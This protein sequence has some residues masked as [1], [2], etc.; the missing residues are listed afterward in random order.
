MTSPSADVAEMAANG[1]QATT[2]ASCIA[3]AAAVVI[4]VPTPLS[5]EGGP[6]L[7][8]VRSAGESVGDY[9]RPGTLVVLEST[10]YPG[11]TEEFLLPILEQRSGLKAGTDFSSGLQPGAHRPRKR[12]T[13]ACRTRRRS[14]A[15]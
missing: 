11:T 5:E 10:T 2:D 3:G 4:C 7:S 12:R 14:S 8:A 1:F 15:A 13:T 6:D 9:L